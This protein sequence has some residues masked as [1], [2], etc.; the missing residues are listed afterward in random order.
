[1]FHN[2]KFVTLVMITALPLVADAQQRQH[3]GKQ[4]E[5]QQR[6]RS[7]RAEA[8][9][10]PE[11]LAQTL[12]PA[13]ARR[14][15]E[16]LQDPRGRWNRWPQ[17]ERPWWKHQRRGYPSGHA[18]QGGFFG[19]PYGGYDFGVDQDDETSSAPP[20]AA[21]S[22]NK[23]LLRFDMVPATGLEYYIDGVYIGSSSNLG[24][25]FEV[26]AG[27]RQVEVRARGY[28]PATFDKRIDEGRV[29]TVR[30]ALEAAEQP[31]APRSTGRQVMYVIP[32]CYMGNAKPAASTLPD[33]CDIRK[34][35]TRGGL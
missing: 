19:V 28:K 24:S 10:P 1:M 6:A 22:T 34:L 26:N 17:S 2:L 33:G 7:A 30:G 9:A 4:Q 31:P 13:G 32:G 23:G 29:T 35:V 20:P 21:P 14:T 8:M 12:L 16:R 15:N 25:E 18:T 11:Q 3:R 5:P 27:A